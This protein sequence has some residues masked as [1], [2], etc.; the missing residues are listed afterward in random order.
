MFI[1]PVPGLPSAEVLVSPVEVF[2]DLLVV[3]VGLCTY[4]VSA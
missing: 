2:V 4:T 3:L 1:V